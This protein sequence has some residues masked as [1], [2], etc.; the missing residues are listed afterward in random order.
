VSKGRSSLLKAEPKKI[1][2]ALSCFEPFWFVEKILLLGLLPK[3]AFVGFF[4]LRVSFM[5]FDVIFSGSL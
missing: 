4:L 2:L 5:D 3:W 1:L